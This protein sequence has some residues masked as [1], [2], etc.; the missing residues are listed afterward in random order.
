MFERVPSQFPPSGQVTNVNTVKLV[1]SRLTDSSP[2]TSVLSRPLSESLRLSELT[3]RRRGTGRKLI[4]IAICTIY[5]RDT[6]S[7]LLRWWYCQHYNLRVRKEYNWDINNPRYY[8]LLIKQGKELAKFEF[9]SSI[10]LIH[11]SR[12]PAALSHFSSSIKLNCLCEGRVRKSPSLW[13]LW[14]VE[15]DTEIE[16]GGGTSVTIGSER[17]ESR[18]QQCLGN[19]SIGEC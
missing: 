2:E 11:H 1:Q 12:P 6:D 4:N 17:T 15:R 7:W 16:K 18:G 5:N 13:S 10:F 9:C 14:S 19:T 3:T 8:L